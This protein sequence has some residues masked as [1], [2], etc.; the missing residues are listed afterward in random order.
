MQR[1]QGGRAWPQRG[2]TGEQHPRPQAWRPVTPDPGHARPVPHRSWRHR[3]PRPVSL[4]EARDVVKQAGGGLV[5]R[6]ARQPGA[7]G[8]TRTRAWTRTVQLPTGSH[9]AERA[10][11]TKASHVE[12]AQPGAGSPGG[13]GAPGVSQWRGATACPRCPDAG[14]SHAVGRPRAASEESGVP[15]PGPARRSLAEKALVPRTGAAPRTGRLPRRA[16]G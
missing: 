2:V 11:R 10:P 8:D 7:T 5:G 3:R 14:R 12:G 9:T 4:A 16:C 15:P 1:R 6:R 13:V